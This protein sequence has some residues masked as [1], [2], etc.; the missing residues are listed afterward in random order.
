MYS[1]GT[2]HE[3]TQSHIAHGLMALTNN[4]ASNDDDSLRNLL[5][6]LSCLNHE[7]SSMEHMGTRYRV[8]LIKCGKVTS[9][10][11]LLSQSHPSTS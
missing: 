7:N 3:C 2:R 8:L 6:I 1:L 4:S 5:C 11:R 9:K 10:T